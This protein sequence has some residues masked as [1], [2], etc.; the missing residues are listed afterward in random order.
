MKKRI[1]GTLY[2]II[3]EPVLDRVYNWKSRFEHE[4]LNYCRTGCKDCYKWNGYCRSTRGETPYKKFRRK[5]YKL[6]D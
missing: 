2:G 3:L 6:D 4:Y 1:I 5:Y